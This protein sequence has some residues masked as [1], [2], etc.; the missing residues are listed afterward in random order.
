MH[1]LGVAGDPKDL[2][3]I[4]DAVGFIEVRFSGEQWWYKMKGQ[5]QT[6][7]VDVVDA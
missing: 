5:L 2:R 4:F 7:V 1:R 3:F 6:I